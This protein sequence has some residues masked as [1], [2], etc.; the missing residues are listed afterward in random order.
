MFEIVFLN[1]IQVKWNIDGLPGCFFEKELIFTKALGYNAA[2]LPYPVY[3]FVPMTLVLKKVETFPFTLFNVSTYKYD[4]YKYDKYVFVKSR[5][6]YSHSIKWLA[7]IMIIH[8][9]GQE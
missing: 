4:F 6:R 2:F 1:K 3:H 9:R 5:L 7:E 8:G